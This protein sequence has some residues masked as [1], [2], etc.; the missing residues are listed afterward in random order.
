MTASKT[1][2]IRRGRES[3]ALCVGVLATQVFLD[4]YAGGGIRPDL[5]REVLTGYSQEAFARR[6]AYPSTSFLLAERVVRDEPYL[7][8]FA[9]L[10][11]DRPAPVSAVS[12]GGTDAELVRL[13]VKRPVQRK[14]LGADLIQ[15]AERTASEQG[16][17]TL[18]LSAWSGN[19]KALAFYR[20]RGYR[21][22]GIH[23]YDFEDRT[24]ETNILVK[25][26]VGGD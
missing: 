18:S 16:A 5:A 1:I 21:T 22:A 11:V 23:E 4:T 9:E 8:A 6:L 12:S 14:G 26:L 17:G 19:R 15:R 20:A 3:D 13:Y 2:V 25:A 24:Y 10:T 7:V